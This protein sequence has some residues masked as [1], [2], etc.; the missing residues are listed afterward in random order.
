MAVTINNRCWARHYGVMTFSDSFFFLQTNTMAAAFYNSEKFR[1][2]AMDMILHN[3]I[4]HNI[5]I[6]QQHKD[7]L[8]T[9][10]ASFK[11]G[12]WF[13]SAVSSCF[14]LILEW[15]FSML[16]TISSTF[17]RT[18]FHDSSETKVIRIPSKSSQ[19][20]DSSI[21]SI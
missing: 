11:V 1:N 19:L 14:F 7:H 16:N 17:S 18:S 4:W 20:K 6:L 10:Q 13:V 8:V 5:F 2:Y 12:N 21:P 9:W 3:L 15:S